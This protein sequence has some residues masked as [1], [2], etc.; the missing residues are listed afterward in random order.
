MA[1]KANMD[2]RLTTDIGKVVS[3]MCK[4]VTR[5]ESMN[6][7]RTRSFYL[8]AMNQATNNGEEASARVVLNK[9]MTTLAGSRARGKEETC[10]LIDSSPLVYSSH[11]C[12]KVN[13]NNNS[14]AI[15]REDGELDGLLTVVDA[16][17]KRMDE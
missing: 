8:S 9:L 7:R 14:R 15:E 16:Y 17:G 10:H 11:V 4:Y 6:T 12:R 2:I 3:Y 13:L 1:F 5:T